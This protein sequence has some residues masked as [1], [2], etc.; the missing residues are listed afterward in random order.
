[1]DNVVLRA[2]QPEDLDAAVAVWLAARAARPGGQPAS[3]QR[4]A[5]IRGQMRK[6][7][8]FLV[9][10]EDAGTVVGMALAMQGLANDGA[11]PPVPGLCFV[12][13]VFVAP[14]RWG[15][16][17]GG[18]VVDALLAEAWSRGYDRAQLWTH[19]NN[20]RA[21]RLY[22]S[23]GF[24]WTGRELDHELGDRIVQYERGR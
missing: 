9:I 22:E 18:R 12:G 13:M 8:A 3:P 11:G 2:G 10:A 23:R 6:P 17:I 1:V 15:E 7:D 14:D 21:Q 24:R 19:A 4:E 5:R 16:G 20:E